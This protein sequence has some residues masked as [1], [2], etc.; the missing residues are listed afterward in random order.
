MRSIYR[1]LDLFIFYLSCLFP[2]PPYHS[3]TLPLDIVLWFKVCFDAYETTQDVRGKKQVSTRAIPY[4][5]IDISIWFF[6]V[7]N[8][9]TRDLGYNSHPKNS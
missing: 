9:D 7:S 8:T 2:H 3:A 4:S 1:I 6:N 5:Y